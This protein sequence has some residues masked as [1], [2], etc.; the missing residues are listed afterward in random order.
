MKQGVV[1]WVDAFA[2]AHG[3]T[4]LADLDVAERVQQSCGWLIE[5]DDMVTVVQSW[6]ESAGM[7]DQVLHVPRCMVREVRY[8]S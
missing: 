2:D 5:R 3:W 7:V 6:D 1:V 4:P 8:I